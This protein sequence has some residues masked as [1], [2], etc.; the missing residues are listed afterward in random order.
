MHVLCEVQLIVSSSWQTHVEH[1]VDIGTLPIVDTRIA[2]VYNGDREG[3]I[4]LN[5]VSNRENSTKRLRTRGLS[6]FSPIN[7]HGTK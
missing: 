7:E 3:G 1:K 6:H 5:T 2:S 4:S